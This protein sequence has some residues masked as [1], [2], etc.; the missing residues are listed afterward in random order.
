LT[1]QPRLENPHSP[2]Q[3]KAIAERFECAVHFTSDFAITVD[4]RPVY[5]EIDGEPV[6]PGAFPPQLV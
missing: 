6:A 3:A 4:G 1:A 5:A 2:E